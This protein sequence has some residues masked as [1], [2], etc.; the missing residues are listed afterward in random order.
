MFVIEDEIHAEW[1][2]EFK[3]Y[4]GAL[5]EFQARSKIAWYAAPNAS[6]IMSSRT[7]SRDYYIL[8]FDRSQ[9]PWREV[10]RTH[11]LCIYSKGSF[12]MEGFDYHENA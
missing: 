7:C 12:W 5:S 10:S 4:M 11:T 9:K 6:P 1:C 3:T 2:G 8:E